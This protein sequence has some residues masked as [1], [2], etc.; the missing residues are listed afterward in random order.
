LEIN[1]HWQGQESIDSHVAVHVT[2]RP[3]GVSEYSDPTA[4]PHQATQG[5]PYQACNPGVSVLREKV[6]TDTDQIQNGA[7]AV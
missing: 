3:S 2:R 1:Q 4:L 7:A 6:D 5:L